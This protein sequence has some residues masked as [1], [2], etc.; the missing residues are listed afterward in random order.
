MKH[1]PGPNKLVAAAAA[2]TPTAHGNNIENHVG[3]DGNA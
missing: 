1:P 2:A 3:H